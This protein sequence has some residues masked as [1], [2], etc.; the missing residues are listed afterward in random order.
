MTLQTHP[1][2]D[3]VLEDPTA[4]VVESVQTDFSK[5]AVIAS[6]RGNRCVTAKDKAHKAK[7][8]RKVMPAHQAAK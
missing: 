6:K 2:S 8:K 3:I 7:T 1:I 5:L 4:R